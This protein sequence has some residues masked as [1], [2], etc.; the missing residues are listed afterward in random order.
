MRTTSVV[1][2]S[3]L[4]AGLGTPAFADRDRCAAVSAEQWMT[5]EKAVGKAE[6]LG[7]AVSEAKRSKGCWEIE[8]YD[9]NGAEIELTLDPVSGDVVKPRGWRPAAKM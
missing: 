8:G 4:V 7:Y 9:R 3:V 1:L 2:A 6:A 5:I